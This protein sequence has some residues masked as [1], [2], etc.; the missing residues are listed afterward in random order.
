[1]S[2]SFDRMHVTTTAGQGIA[3][4]GVTNFSFTN[5]TIDN[6]GTG[7]AVDSS[8]IGFNTVLGGT[9]A[10]VSGAVTITGNSLSTSYYHGIDIQN[11]SGT[12]SDLNISNNT[13]TSDTVSA[14]SNGTA[15]RVDANDSASSEASITKG[16]LNGNTIANFPGGA[17]ILLQ[18][19]N[20]TSGSPVGSAGTP[21]DA[22]NVI[23]V[24]NNLI[25]GHG[26]ATSTD[27]MGTQAINLSVSGHGQG[28]FDI[29]SNGTAANPLANMNGVAIGCSA[30]GAV[31]VDCRGNKNVMSPD[32][33]VVNAQPGMA[34]GADGNGVATAAPTLNSTITNNTVHQSNGNGILAT[35]RGDSGTANFKIQNNV[36]DAPLNGVRPGIRVDSGNGLAGENTS[37]CL[38]ISG[39]TSAVSGGTQGIGL[40]KQG[41][42]S[43][44]DAFAINGMAATSSPGV[45]T[46]V[47]G[48][49]PAGGGTL[50]ISATSGFSN[51]SL[52][53]LAVGGQQHGGGN[54]T[55]LTPAEL[56]SVIHGALGGGRAGGVSA[57][58]A[59]RL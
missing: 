26:N 37:V 58:G 32:N 50:L 42:I 39:N 52:P 2:P 6:T 55:P 57:R 11:Y 47:N 30:F 29:D 14:N 36:V 17:G 7:H 25:H 35:N 3:G 38:N 1:R 16:E 48:L 8:N 18:V 45:E 15:I 41:T 33:L 28:N 51:C 49:N 27:E 23:Q 54:S 34:I 12:I 22:T 40:R 10:N 5:G 44:V 21:G 13:F 24:H 56:A 31:Q 19:V 59:A 53:L 43:N 9:T 4:T 20:P 46:F